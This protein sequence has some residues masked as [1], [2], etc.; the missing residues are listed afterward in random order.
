MHGLNFNVQNIRGTERKNLLNDI[1][2]Q[3]RDLENNK[4]DKSIFETEKHKSRSQFFDIQSDNNTQLNNNT[5]NTN[6]IDPGQGSIQQ[7]LRVLTT[8]QMQKI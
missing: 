8:L 7:L 6:N 1:I 4:N 5:L 2:Q 3:K